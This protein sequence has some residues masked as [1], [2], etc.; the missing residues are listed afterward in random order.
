MLEKKKLMLEHAFVRA[1]PCQHHSTNARHSVHLTTTV[2]R[3]TS[4]E[5][6]GTLNLGNAFSDIE[7]HW[8]EMHF[9]VARF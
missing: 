7:E 4:G 9:H 6:L 2:I 3:R 5:N 1:F 8:T